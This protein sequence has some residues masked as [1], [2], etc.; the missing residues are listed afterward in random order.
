VAPPGEGEVL[1]EVG[2][3]G[4]GLTVLNY[5]KGQLSD[6]RARLPVVPGHEFWG[7][8]LAAGPG[9]ASDLVG[10][11]VVAY[12]Y[13]SC[14]SC[15][16]CR[17]GQESLCLRLAGRVGTHRDGGYAPFAVLPQLNVVEVP[18]DLDPVAATVVADAV[19]TPLHVASR[20][21][22]GPGDRVAVVGAGGG[23]GIHMVQVAGRRGAMV[24]G[25]D[26]TDEKLAEV[27]RQ[28]AIPIRS[29]RFEDLGSDLFEQ[30]PPTVV[31]DLVGN[32]GSLSW[33]LAALGMGGRLV[34]L[35]TFPGQDL[36]LEPRALVGREISVLA[37]RYASRTEVAEAARLVASGEI[38][39]VIGQVRAAG[40]ALE[41]HRLLEAGSL[42]GRGAIDWRRPR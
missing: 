7:R 21:R 6:Q 37:S 19:A 12:F 10:R 5:L 18:E 39:P 2:A 15:D 29:E 42:V 32:R 26:L 1:V 33:G 17:L 40:Q 14:G 31:V 35:T 41:L 4:V 11:S 16:Y 27:E 22:I 34:T 20:A 24:A 38:N 28:G 23:V 8:V 30:G 3:C 36:V 13:L 9:V 25:L